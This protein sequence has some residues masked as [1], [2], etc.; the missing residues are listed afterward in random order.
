MA[1]PSQFV[2]IY[3]ACITNLRLDPTLDKQKAK[4][5]VNAIY[6]QVCVETEA[7]PTVATTTL[8]V[9]VSS[10]TLPS[11]ISRLKTLNVTPV[12]G[13]QTRPMLRISLDRMLAY[14]SAA[15]G[16]GTNNG[17]VYAYSIVGLNEFEVYPAPQNADT[18]TFYYTARPTALSGDTDTPVIP[19]PYATDCLVYG[20]E[21]RLAQ[22]SGDPD[23]GY[24]QQLYADAMARFKTHINR[25]AGRITTQMNLQDDKLWPPHDPSVD[26]RDFDYG[27][28]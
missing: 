8:S 7:L 28:V 14:R 1:Y 4:D 12:G 13:Y 24:Y 23:I 25:L 9:G 18:L 11:N 22:F 5:A 19:E 3:T 16:P 27:G 15:A 10:Y 21:A 26:M 20:A 2:D 6:T 17:T